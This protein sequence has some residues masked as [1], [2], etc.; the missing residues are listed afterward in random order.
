MANEVKVEVP[1]PPSGIP[2][3]LATKWKQTYEESF[4]EAVGD[5]PND[6]IQHKQ[7]ATREA[8]KLLKVKKPESYEEAMRI[9][10]WQVAHRQERDGVLNVVTF[11]GNKYKFDVPQQRKAMKG[12]DQQG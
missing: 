2:E 12:T 10:K 1:N 7:T 5:F 4:L 6:H 3:E 11:D 9:P 8:N